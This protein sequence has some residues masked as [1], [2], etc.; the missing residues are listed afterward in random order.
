MYSSVTALSRAITA[1]GRSRSTASLGSPF[2]A[3]ERGTVGSFESTHAA[4]TKLAA[5]IASTVRYAAGWSR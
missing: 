4:R 5:S 3:A 1:Y 2:A